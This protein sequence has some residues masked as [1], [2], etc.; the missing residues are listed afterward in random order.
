M[1]IFSPLIL[2]LFLALGALAGLLA[3]MLGI[4]GGIIFVPLFL[5]AFPLAGFPADLVVHCAFGTS[6]AII[7]PTAVSSSLAHRRHDNVDWHQVYRL[8]LGGIVGAVT[9]AS[10]AAAL[11]G[12]RLKGLFGLMQILVALKLFF[13]PRHL[14]PERNTQ[15]PFLS[16]LLVGMAGG[17]FAAFFG[18]GGG[19]VAVPLMVIAL[20]LPIQL[21]V[22]NSSALIVVSS[23][24][25]A[26]SYVVHGWQV[27][28]LP[29]FSVGYVNLLVVA[30]VAPFATVGARFGVRIASRLSHDKL[31][32]IF[33][34]LLI[35][36]G[37]RMLIRT[38]L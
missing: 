11:S 33:A 21:A 18:V 13:Q 26:L 10:L 7:I 28:Q 32:K 25:G 15:V 22:G 12:D 8:S 31:V 6:L 37:L 1:T 34:G 2:I 14:P 9:G 29:P 4:G 38:Y 27:P 20:Q 5:W 23:I 35:L 16:L 17:A 3:G 24:A 36:I 30:M 19:V